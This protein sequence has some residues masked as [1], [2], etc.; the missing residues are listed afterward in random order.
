MPKTFLDKLEERKREHGN[1]KMGCF[2]DQKEKAW[3][4]KKYVH[5]TLDRFIDMRLAYN[6]SKTLYKELLK[7]GFGKELLD[8]YLKGEYEI[9]DESVVKGV[10]GVEYD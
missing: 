8:N 1:Y 4:R 10:F 5:S 9:I 6:K 7:D 3:R 2:L